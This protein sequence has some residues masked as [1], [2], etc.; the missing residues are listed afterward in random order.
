MWFKPGQRI[1]QWRLS[2][3]S[4]CSVTGIVIGLNLFGAFQLLEWAALDSWFRARPLEEPDP[5]IVILG[6]NEQDM[7]EGPRW[8]LSDALMADLIQKIA[9]QNPRVIG[10]DIYRD[11]PLEPGH[12]ELRQVMQSTPQLMGI[13]KVFGDAIAPPPGLDPARQVGFTDVVVDADGKVRRGLVSVRTPDNEVKFSIGAKLALTYLEAEDIIPAGLDAG[14]QTYQLGRSRFRRFEANDG[15]YVRADDGGYQLLLNFRGANCANENSNCPFQIVSMGEFLDNQL[16]PDFLQDRIVLIGITAASRQDNFYSP[17]SY[18]PY[19][20]R[21]VTS[22]SGVEVHAHLT[23][24]MISAALD[25]RPLIKTWPDFLEYLWIFVWAGCGTMLVPLCLD[26]RRLT[27]GLLWMTGMLACLLGGLVGG[28]Y[29][30]FLMGW[31]LPVITPLSALTGATVVGTTH[32]LLAK[33]KLSYQALEHANQQLVDYSQTLEQKVEDRTADLLVA[34]EAADSANRAKN[35]FLANMSHELRTPLNA[36]LGTTQLLEEQIVGALNAEQIKTLQTTGRSARH[37]L[38]L[39]ND[40]L[41]LARVESGRLTLDC[42]PTDVVALCQFCLTVVK[43]QAHKKGLRLDAK[44]PDT[45]PLLIVDERRVR[46]V[47][48]NL[49]SNAVK[50]TSSGGSVTLE[51]GYQSSLEPLD[52]A[53]SSSPNTLTF[54]VRDTGIG[55]SSEYMENLFKPFVQIDSALNRR[56]GGTGLGLALIKSIV[57]LHGGKVSVWSEVGVGSCF[58]VELPCDSA[59]SYLSSTDTAIANISQPNSTRPERSASILLVED[60]VDNIAATIKYLAAKGYRVQVANDGNQA[61][62]AVLSKVPDLILMDIQMP[63]MDGLEAIQQIRRHPHLADVPIIALT[64]LA[65]RG[66]RERCLAAGADDY[67]SKPVRLSQLVTTINRF[68]T[69]RE[70]PTPVKP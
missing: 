63:G 54:T 7:T 1:W 33:L 50:F 3:A 66:D 57:E 39:I 13:E 37:L 26:R 65:M 28:A 4:A 31:W 9:A 49:L 64:A 21:E 16:P 22:M 25:G 62:A 70:R 30:A 34:K 58:T 55:I 36:I 18:S 2:I 29:L 41:D 24:Q 53:V 48:I 15:G 40:I 59:T 67:L 23:S 5:R 61:I 43:Q 17:Y 56:Y 68:L 45:L 14:M 44:L 12:Q 8:P 51:L 46:E 10:L 27:A 6:I 19:P 11:V 69:D 32:L 20:Y 52:T 60:D 47:I 35:D 38:S 42:A